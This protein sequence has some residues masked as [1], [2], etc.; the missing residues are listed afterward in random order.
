MNKSA[1]AYLA[2][3]ASV[4]FLL[5][6]QSASAASTDE[7]RAKAY[8]QAIAGGNAETI[9]SFYA[10]KAEFHWVGGPLAGIYK[11]KPQIQGVWRKF[12][13]AAGEM[14]HKIVEISESRNG[15]ISTVTAKVNFIGP[16]EVPVKF[17]LMYEDGKITNEIWQVDKEPQSYAKAEPAPAPAPAPKKADEPVE[18]PTDSAAAP[19]AAAGDQPRQ[20]I[21]TVTAPP[22]GAPAN[23]E[24]AE[25]G[26]DAGPN[27]GP[28]ATL[29]PP[30][31][32]EK[33]ASDPTPP[34]KKTAEVKKPQ[35][36]TIGGEEYD[37]Y[38]DDDYYDE[39]RRPRRHYFRRYYGDDYGYYDRGY[40]FGNG[41]YRYRGG[42]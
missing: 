1:L 3:A 12:V 23:G 29:A 14:K 4:S 40:R 10:E 16:K 17:I 38:D 18:Q 22:P 32:P 5:G 19:D 41:Y 9:A 27:G 8:F 34:R 21:A 37:N 28:S 6:A 24:P 39:Y 30:P 25:A 42:Y 15:R 26:P 31:T 2:A 13:D 11:G 35:N 33:R 20:V 36:K 7:L